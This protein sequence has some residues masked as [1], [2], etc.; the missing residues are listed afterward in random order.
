MLPGTY[1][2]L[3]SLEADAASIRTYQPRIVPGLLQTEVYVRAMIEAARV[4]MS[5]EEIETVV[6]VRLARQAVFTRQRPLRLWAV[7]DEA[8]LR[9]MVGGT[10]VMRDQLRHLVVMA[11]R[12]NVTLQVLPFAV[13]APAWV[14]TPF[15]VLRFPEPA[16]LEV[17]YLENLTSGLYVEETAEVDRYTL[18]FDYLR[19]AALSP[20]E[21]VAL[22]AE[23]A[24]ALE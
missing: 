4:E 12:Q 20:K 23:V 21:S 2:D 13:G 19:A 5:P 16:D 11:K 17:V 9:R 1:L 24:D 7:L 10:E 6:E 14:H 8:V 18:M 3:I 15:V 22:I